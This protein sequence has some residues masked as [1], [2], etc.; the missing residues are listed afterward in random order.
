M[1]PST[2]LSILCLWA[3]LSVAHADD[4]SAVIERFEKAGARIT[5]NTE[6]HAVKV[7][8]GG[9]PPHSLAE[10]QSLVALTHLEELALNAPAAGN[11]DWAFLHNLKHLKKLTIW[12]CKTIQSLAPF[13]GLTIESLTVGGS[14][15]LRDLNKETP[16]EH[17][18]AV[19][20]LTDLPN[21][22]SINLY[23]TPLLPKDEHLAHLISEFPKLEE[24]K[25]DCA[26]PRGFEVSITPAG[27][28][29]L[30]ALP[31]RVLSFEN[32]EF[33][34]DEHIE[35]IAGIKTLEALL[36]DCRKNPFDTTSLEASL[37]KLRPDLEVQ[38]AGEDSK[39]PPTRSK[40]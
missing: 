11:D 27:L 35:S 15:G 1:R 6:G 40:K 31:I 37:A 36:V 26:A 12:H 7:F 34:T 28:A 30:G 3:L 18:N 13:S 14:M 9:R 39:G 32:I 25:I 19:L 17:L 33:F 22:K 20:T 2:T 29:K 10:L 24:V 8:S 38:V 4:E 21:L 5:K 16:E 23:H